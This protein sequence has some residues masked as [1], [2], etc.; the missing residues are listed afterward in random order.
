MSREAKIGAASLAVALVALATDYFFGGG[1]FDEVGAD[2]EDVAGF[3]VGAIVSAVVAAFLYGWLI[4]RSRN[5]PADGNRPAK[6]GLATSIVAAVTVLAAWLGLPYVLAPGAVLLGRMGQERATDEGRKR[7][8]TAAVV[9][10]AIAF[11]LAIVAVF[12]DT[13]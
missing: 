6:V 3:V 11:L 4:P 1:D 9:I 13:L 10:G 12:S 7:V 2:A 8:A 5:A